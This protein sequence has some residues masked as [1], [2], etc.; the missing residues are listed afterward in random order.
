VLRFDG[1]TAIITG[2]GGGLGREYA[3]LLAQRGA[4]VVVNDV[5]GE[6][7]Q[8]VVAEIVDV[9]GSAIASTE[10]V[11][12]AEGGDR[13]V[14]AALAEFGGL[15]IVVNN[16]GILRDKAFHNLTPD[17]LEP[18][19]DVHLR[20][21]FFVTRPAWEHMR[22]RS[23]GRVINTSS[24]SG[25]LGNFGQSNYGAAKAGLV[26][27]TR[28]LATEGRRFNIHANVIAPS[29]HTAMTEGLLEPDIA[30]ALG[31]AAVAPVVAWLAHRDCEVSGEVYTA[32]GGRVARFFTGLT[33]GYFS[34]AL[35]PEQVAD[36]VSTIRDPEGYTIPDAPIE[37]IEQLKAHWAL[38]REGG[39]S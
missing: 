30:A 3:L 19:L 5:S 24:N 16:A 32:G 26:G 39:T 14:K 9:G 8:R 28:V 20:G 29:A 21:A 36:H 17:L 22:E 6:H 4:A 11:A 15:E 12:T 2:A 13:L 31:P 18:V 25:I 34:P 23:Y 38:Q 37:E 7:A 10:S 33:P 1:Q 35:T 27:L